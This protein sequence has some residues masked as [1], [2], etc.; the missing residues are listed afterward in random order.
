[1]SLTL[2]IRPYHV[3]NKVGSQECNRQGVITRTVNKA[4]YVCEARKGPSLSHSL[5][6]LGPLPPLED[7]DIIYS[8]DA[9][10]AP[11]ETVGLTTLVEKAE[12]EFA[13]RETDR[14]VRTEYEMLDES[15]ET[16]V[17]KGKGKR[18]SPKQRAEATDE[19]DWE[20]I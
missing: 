3:G 14:I 7:A 2:Y 17:N 9:H 11:T 19:D 18:G 10:S 6:D 8:F 12:K 15:G 13:S 4:D 5:G 16:V 20:E 1:M